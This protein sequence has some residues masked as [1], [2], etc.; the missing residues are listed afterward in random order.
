VKAIIISDADGKALLDQLELEKM[1]AANHW[2]NH[3]TATNEAIVEAHRA[4][5]YI[6]TKW[7]QEMGADTLRG[8]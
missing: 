5:H 8:R 2:P 6:V 3:S 4:F 7:L 1:K